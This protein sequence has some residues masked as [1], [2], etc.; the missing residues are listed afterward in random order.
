MSGRRLQ[1]RLAFCPLGCRNAKGAT[2]NV[3]SG[4]CDKCVSFSNSS[5]LEQGA[6]SKTL[7]GI[8]DARSHEASL[9]LIP[10]PAVSP[11]KGNK[12]AIDL[13][14][15][16]QKFVAALHHQQVG[17]VGAA[18][19]KPS[20]VECG[21]ELTAEERKT[22]EAAELKT[23]S[24]IGIEVEIRE[25]I[26]KGRGV[27]AK[28]IAKKGKYLA[29]YDG[30]RVDMITGEMKM[31]CSR[32]KHLLTKVSPTKKFQIQQ[33]RYSKT[34]ALTNRKGGTR[35]C[36]DG[37]VSASP[38]L[39]NVYNRGGVGIGAVLNSSHKSKIAPN[40]KLECI[41]RVAENFTMANF[42]FATKEE[43]FDVVAVA[44]RD[45]EPDEELTY[46]YNW[47]SVRSLSDVVES[48]AAESVPPQSAAVSHHGSHPGP[49]GCV[50]HIRGNV[51]SLPQMTAAAAAEEE[52]ARPADVLGVTVQVQQ[53]PGVS[54]AQAVQE[55][56][57]DAPGADDDDELPLSPPSIL[58]QTKLE[59]DL[60]GA[61]DPKSKKTS[62]QL[63]ALLTSAHTSWPPPR[64]F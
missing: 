6:I 18:A 20:E 54:A 60:F 41:P 2:F 34:W 52:S 53:L 3:G 5:V 64:P 57:G 45:I 39:D 28:V 62:V 14:R 26:G 35:V 42:F 61:G 9:A 7:I 32:M 12:E 48:D 24:I 56:I 8:E 37:T 50:C 59:Q 36:I 16:A 47:D 51:T 30:N 38:L 55:E 44:L 11:K 19:Q 22:K 1:I 31:F 25:S 23:V 40:C 63:K 10:S 17:G 49:G 43:R 58:P 13:T 15:D 33:L 29:R 46:V 27:F 4:S 21:D